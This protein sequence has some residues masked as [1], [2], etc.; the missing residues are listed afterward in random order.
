MITKMAASL[1]KSTPRSFRHLKRAM[2]EKSNVYVK[3]V[4][5]VLRVKNVNVVLPTTRFMLLPKHHFFKIQCRNASVYSPQHSQCYERFSLR[6]SAHRR[7]LELRMEFQ[8][9]LMKTVN[10]KVP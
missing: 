8:I 9:A 5:L 4:L 2:L 3:A 6:S 7:Q 10:S 1:Y